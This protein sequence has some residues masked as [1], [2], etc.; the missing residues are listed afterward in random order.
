MTRID[1]DQ[2][3]SKLHVTIW[4]IA[5]ELRGSVDG[6]DPVHYASRLCSDKRLVGFSFGICSMGKKILKNPLTRDSYYAIMLAHP[7]CTSPCEITCEVPGFSFVR[8]VDFRG[9]VRWKK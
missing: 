9:A 2:Q 3:Q 7:Q 5:N 8:F 1:K 6:W 4:Q